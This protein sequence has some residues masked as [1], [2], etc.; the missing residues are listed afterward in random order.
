MTPDRE[1]R[2]FD[3]T[4]P[5][6]ILTLVLLAGI[7][8][9]S[10]SVFLPSLPS[11]TVA[12]DT[13]YEVMQLAV[14]LYLAVTAFIQIVV[15]PLADRYGR[16]PV[17]L[18][19]LGIF[20]AA[21]VGCLL[22]PTAEIFLGFRMLQAAVATGIVL[23]RAVVRD[24][25]PPAESASMIGYVTMGM[26][27]VPMIAPMIGGALDQAFGWRSTFVFLILAGL[28]VLVLTWADMGE[29]KRSEPRSFRDQ[30]AETPEL[31]RSRRFWGYVAAAAFASGSFFAFLG[32]APYVASEVYGLSAF[33]AG[34]AFGAPATG[35]AIGNYLS[36]RFSARRG[37]NAM[38]VAGT[39]LTTVGLA[40]AALLT[41][42]G[43]GSAPVFFGFCTFIG[44][45]NGL[46]IPNASA[47]M[48]SVRPHL[49]GTASGFGSAAMIGGGALLS[50]FAGIVL[51]LGDGS[52][53]L[54]VLMLVSSLLAVAAI[55]YVIAREAEVAA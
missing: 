6:H 45:G 28:G 20:V 52:L 11:M 35:Y 23:S 3:R 13:S 37:I 2:L 24:L 44:L 32:G 4:S 51:R 33:W 22:A 36:G 40:L 49:A 50:V 53:P 17:T 16:R 54:I 46:V 5:P 12:F 8:A 31:F 47:G 48:L 30:L 29:T 34:A 55:R 18:A 27:L 21:S 26:A 38:I 41:A 10:M 9:M 7:G 42:A 43:L 1:A 39:M 19:A 25:Y 15:G 14:S